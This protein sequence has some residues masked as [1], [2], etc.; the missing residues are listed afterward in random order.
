MKI[1]KIAN[2]Q[3]ELN[4][5]LKPLSDLNIEFYNQDINT[6]VLRF[7]L[8]QCGAGIKISLNKMQAYIMLIAEDGSKVRDYLAIYDDR[9]GIVSYTIPKEFLKH[10][11]R[12][13]G[14]VYLY[15]EDNVLVTRTFSFIIKD[16]LVNDFS[17]ETMLEYIKTFDDLES[18]IKAKATEIEQ[19]IAN[20]AD[21]VSE[22][23]K[24]VANGQ[25]KIGIS[26]TQAALDI[27]K[28]TS[29]AENTIKTTATESQQAIEKAVIGA[30]TTVEETSTTAIKTVSET[31]ASVLKKIIEYGQVPKI[32]ADN[33]TPRYD[34]N[35]TKDFFEE[36]LKWG[37]GLF[38]FYLSAGAKNNP[39][40]TTSWLRGSVFI[41]GKN[42]DVTAFDKLGTMYTVT[43]A[44]GNYGKW[45]TVVSEV[46]TNNWQK[47]ALLP[48]SGVRHRLENGTDLLT[49]KSGFY[50]VT[51]CKNGP[52]IETEASWKELEVI[53]ADK[54]RK[55][56]KLTLSGN[57]RTFF[58]TVHTNGSDGRDWWELAGKEDIDVAIKTLNPTTIWQGA[59]NGVSTT[60][61]TL[62]QPINR[63]NKIRI[64]YNFPGAKGKVKVVDLSTTTTLTVQDLNLTDIDAKGGGLYE[65]QLDFSALN[66][67]KIVIDS[68]YDLNA[69]GSIN[70]KSFTIL[71]VEEVN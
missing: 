37:N 41:Y 19:A 67:F 69:S 33:G 16:S 52:F 55:F 17:P 47:Y 68:V 57:G 8:T 4:S 45:V 64:T 3:L 62:S 34:L 56:F 13:T 22:M 20:G 35:A 53:E 46:K 24:T 61:Y 60:A 7:T 70:R 28:T 51:Q 32:T 5:Q 63:V 66:N 12:V 10:T 9:K 44:N 38:T 43:C 6:A 71:K 36:T 26:V 14:Q 54:G 21:Y 49:L 30:K 48:E 18:A 27:E 65:L 2:A 42:I 23:N 39:T 25:K 31:S 15:C 1:K 40:G 29:H 11:G 58:R 59:A 50:E